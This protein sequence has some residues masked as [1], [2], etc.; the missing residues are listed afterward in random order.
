MTILYVY[1]GSVA[2]SLTELT[3]GGIQSGTAGRALLLIG[4]VATLVLTILIT[5]KATQTLNAHLDREIAEAEE[6]RRNES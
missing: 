2:K 1:L 5:R 3:S 4:L 6:S